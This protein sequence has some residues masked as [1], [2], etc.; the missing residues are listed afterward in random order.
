MLLMKHAPA[1]VANTEK[2]AV[3]VDFQDHLRQLEARNLVTR[4][5]HPINK[6]TELHP[7]VRLQFLGDLAENE[8]RAFLFTNVVDG[9]GKRLDI[10]V[11]VGSFAASPEISAQGMGC[12]VGEIGAAWLK[13]MRNPIAPVQVPSGE[14]QDVI[15]TGDA[16]RGPDGGLKKLPIPISTPGFDSAPYLTATLCVTKDPESGIQNM[17]TYRAGLKATDRI[18]MRMVVGENGAG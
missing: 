11:V 17:G 12:A 16:L 2:P 13:A 15:M 3:S 4:I 6:D 9:T 1:V 14:C 8:R 5:D 10:P 7:L 18:A